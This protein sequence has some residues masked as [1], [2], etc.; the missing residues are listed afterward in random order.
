MQFP[1]NNDLATT[2]HK[3]QGKAKIF[4]VISQL[5]YGTTNWIFV[6]L[7]RVTTLS[8]LFLLHPLK[9]NYNPKHPKLLHIE[10]KFQRDTEI[11]TLLILHKFGNYSEN[12]DITPQL[13]Q[14][15]DS[16]EY[17]PSIRST[18]EATNHSARQSSDILVNCDL[19]LSQHNMERILHLTPQDGNCLFESVSYF[20][21]R[22]KGKP[23]ELRFNSI[24][25]DQQQVSQGT[26]WGMY[27]WLKFDDTRANQDSYGEL[28]YLHYLEY[29]MDP[30]V[31]GTDYD[32]VMLCEFLQVSIN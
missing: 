31:Y 2:G 3:L 20:S 24:K 12:I 10:W 29:M 4:L 21:D 19:C 26:E 5:N 15:Q 30:K 16:Q 11:E 8:G 27:M 18:R 9:I 17:L 1:I 13:E 6:V 14:P 23:V 22:W 7:S 28:S 32:L 25:W